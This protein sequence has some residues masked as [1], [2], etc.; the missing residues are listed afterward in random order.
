MDGLKHGGGIYV[1]S[2]DP[3]EYYEG[4]WDQGQ[5]IG[6]G[7]YFK[8]GNEYNGEWQANKRNGQGEYIS[9]DGSRYSGRWKNDQLEEGVITYP[10]GSGTVDEYRGELSRGLRNGRGVYTYSNGGRYEGTYRDDLRQGK[11]K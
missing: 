1:Y 2:Y 8:D 9:K 11:G 4:G 5:K 6:T 7:R 10:K 3:L